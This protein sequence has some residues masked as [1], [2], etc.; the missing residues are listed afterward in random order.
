MECDLL[1]YG[2]QIQKQEQDFSPK[3][4]ILRTEATDSTLFEGP[5][6]IIYKIMRDVKEHV[7]VTNG[8]HNDT[9]YDGLSHGESSYSYPH[10]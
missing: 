7:V 6:L 10:F 4:R 1:D 3:N 5:S 2:T 9:I 8:S